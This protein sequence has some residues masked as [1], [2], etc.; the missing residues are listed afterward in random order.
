MFEL[1]DELPPV[2]AQVEL[3]VRDA[4]GVIRIDIQR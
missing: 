3:A 4:H 2:P 1:L